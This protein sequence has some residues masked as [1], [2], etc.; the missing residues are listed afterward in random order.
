MNKKIILLVFLI[1]LTVLTTQQ[2]LSKEPLCE[3]EVDII[4]H[5]TSYSNDILGDKSNYQLG[6]F[7]EGDYLKI[8]KILIKKEGNCNI[9]NFTFYPSILINNHLYENAFCS[10]REICSN[11]INVPT[12][13]ETKS[14]YSIFLKNAKIKS[15]K[16]LLYS[17]LEYESDN[18]EKYYFNSFRISDNGI[19]RIKGNLTENS[20]E[21]FQKFNL[22]GVNIGFPKITLADDKNYVRVESNIISF[23]YAALI[24]L[25]KDNKSSFKTS[26]L[27]TILIGLTTIIVM[28]YLGKWQTDKQKEF[29]KLK[30]RGVLNSL[31]AILNYLD[32]SPK[33]KKGYGQW[34]G[35]L[36]AAKQEFSKNNHISFK[37]EPINISP[38]LDKLY[39]LEGKFNFK[40]I[41]ENLTLINQKIEEIN[42]SKTQPFSNKEFYQDL[43]TK[44]KIT[45]DLIKITKDE[46]NKIVNK[47]KISG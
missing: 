11:G 34:Q 6:T 47:I 5:I 16:W 28:I 9:P 29:E 31:L 1:I 12:L 37:I 41:I 35:N 22:I 26:I 13:N 45:L 15:G 32:S 20:I 40:E 17:I 14:T 4:I 43:L 30:L 23:E 25:I 27:I 8:D 19:L 33:D 3:G 44:T 38:Y 39:S 7:R 18:N 2:I 21:N 42:H 46:I 24:E 10:A 36:T